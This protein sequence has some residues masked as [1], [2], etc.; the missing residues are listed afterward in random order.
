M[1]IV[2]QLPLHHSLEQRVLDLILA[3]RF[4]DTDNNA[5]QAPILMD[6]STDDEVTIASRLYLSGIGPLPR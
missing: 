1:D 6:P 4:A 3:L 2:I 5:G